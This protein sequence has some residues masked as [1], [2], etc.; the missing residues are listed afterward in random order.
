MF[1]RILCPIDFSKFSKLALD[2][3]VAVARSYGAEVTALHA[4][5]S[6]SMPVLAAS[7]A[8]EPFDVA[9]ARQALESDL[10][11]WTQA[12]RDLDVPISEVVTIGHPVEQILELASRM[13]AD[14]IVMGTHGLGGFERL[15]LGS[16]AEKVLRKAPCPVLTVSGGAAALRPSTSLSFK[17]ILCPVDFSRSSERAVQMAS[18]LARESAGLVSLLHV[19]E[20][21]EGEPAEFGTFDVP[22]YR[23][24]LR[25][26]AEQ[27]LDGMVKDARPGCE[28]QTI[29]KVGKAWREIVQTAEAGDVDLIVMGVLGRNALNLLLFGS[30]THHVVREAACPVLSV[31][32]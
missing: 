31:R 16:V 32:G 12:V 2:Y 26:N 7:P 30:T 5:E 11:K 18:S 8:G 17:R 21:C 20:G 28:V 13:P 9:S 14:L 22:E 23:A 29:V 10:A 6:V 1:D 4:A 3:A 24:H 19:V 27:R 25:R 15:M